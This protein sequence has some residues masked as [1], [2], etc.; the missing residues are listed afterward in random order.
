MVFQELKVSF[1]DTMENIEDILND[2]K[3]HNKNFSNKIY[4]HVSPY[5]KVPDIIKHGILSKYDYYMINK[6]ALPES[7]IKICE[8][9]CCVNGL[10]CVSLARMDLEN[11][12]V[13][14]NEMVYDSFNYFL[15]DI[16]VDEN[17][18]ANR[19]TINYSNEFLYSK[20]IV[21]E[22]IKSIDVRIIELLNHLNMYE[23]DEYE[24]TK[25]AIEYLNLLKNI[26][27]YIKESDRD[28][29]LR[30]MSININLDL[31][32]ISSIPTL[33]LK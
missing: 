25:K 28:I 9:E 26:A 1:S 3:I 13:Y 18:K 14:K 10:Y 7:L 22:H 2:C 4:H 11:L 17:I 6:I 29:S 31:D 33:I 30:E 12:D 16:L 23:N 5:N 21:P 27:K 8:D 32:K 20:S 15:A 24:K 19:N